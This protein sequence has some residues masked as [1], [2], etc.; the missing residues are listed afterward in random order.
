[1]IEIKSFTFNPLQE[2][3]Y[4]LY[5]ET[6][7]CVIIDPGCY[8]EHE[9]KELAD[10]ISNNNLK[11]VRLLNTHCHIDHVLGNQ[12]IADTYKLGLEIHKEDLKL[13]HSVPA[14]APSYG[15]AYAGSPEPSNFIDEGDII[16]FGNS[17]LEILFTP[18]HAPGHVTF[19]NR[20]QEFM[21]SGDVL[22]YQ[23]IGRTDLPGGDYQTLINSVTQKLFTI[24]DNYIVYCGHGPSTTIGQERKYNPFF[25][26]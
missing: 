1:M 26:Q 21:I 8:Q 4:L 6:K 2:N 9:R 22:F 3:T 5:D 18:G 7:E 16:E 17:K 10:F 11:P 15:I 12:F 25:N 20:A 13:L 24:G 23:S 19:Y 14:Y